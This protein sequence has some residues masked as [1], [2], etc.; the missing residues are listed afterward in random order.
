ME[1]I[2]VEIDHFLHYHLLSNVV[3]HVYEMD[4]VN[5]L[6]HVN[7]NDAIYLHEMLD[8]VK[9]VLNDL[10]ETNEDEYE[11]MNILNEMIE[12]VN[13]MVNVDLADVVMVNVLYEMMND[14]NE[15]VNDLNE[16]MNDEIMNHKNEMIDD[17]NEVVNVLYEM[18]DDVNEMLNI[19]INS[20]IW[21]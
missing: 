7:V 21:T 3:N 2:V 10:N 17:K 8:L 9:E 12:D 18:I 6:N 16:M 20:L 15:M 1:D 13:E 5:K 14:E 11:M 19:E 4:Q